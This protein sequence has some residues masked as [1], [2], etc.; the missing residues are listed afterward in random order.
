MIPGKRSR[1]IGSLLS[2]LTVA[3]L[4]CSRSSFTTADLRSRLEVCQL[5]GS[6]KDKHRKQ[7]K[8][9]KRKVLFCYGGIIP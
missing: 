5:G 7:P 3:G 4:Q 2:E 8:S 9:E 6:R 1:V